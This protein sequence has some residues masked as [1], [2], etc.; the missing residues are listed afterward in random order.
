MDREQIGR[1]LTEARKLTNHREYVIVGSLSIL[2]KIANPPAEMVYSIDVDMY[3]R[4][5]PGRAGEIADSLGQGTDFEQKHGYYADAVSPVLPTLPEGWEERLVRI[6]YP[7]HVVGLY[8]DPND[9]AVSK[10][11][12]LEPRDRRWIREGFKAGV[13]DPAVIEQRMRSAPFLDEAEE[14]RARDALRLDREWL[15]TKS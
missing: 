12:R 1:L 11:A 4:L 15:A 5:D 13:L 2:G 8:L 10:Y 7:D 9:C 3:P 6:E 14:V